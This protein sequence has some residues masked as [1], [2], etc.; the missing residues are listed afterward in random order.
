[1]LSSDTLHV[2]LEDFLL[3]IYLFYHPQNNVQFDYTH[4]LH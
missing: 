2:F 1:M 4:R 3:F